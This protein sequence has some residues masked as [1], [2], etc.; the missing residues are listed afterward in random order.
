MVDKSCVAEVAPTTTGSQ[1]GWSL[2]YAQLMTPLSPA[3]ARDAPSLELPAAEPLLD[4]L[5]QAASR[6]AADATAI[7]TTA[8]RHTRR[9]SNSFTGGISSRSFRWGKGLLQG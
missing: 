3:A 4:E 8:R 6:A 1:F 2:V 5:V 9:R 7:G